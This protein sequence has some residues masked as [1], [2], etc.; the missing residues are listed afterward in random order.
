MWVDKALY[1]ATNEGDDIGSWWK[2]CNKQKPWFHDVATCWK[3]C[4]VQE[5]R[6]HD[7]TSEG[8]ASWWKHYNE[9]KT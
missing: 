7:T 8:T 2:H 5:P 3:H 4:N 1:N 6:N 9:Q